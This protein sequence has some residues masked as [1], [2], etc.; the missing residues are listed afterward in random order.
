VTPDLPRLVQLG[1]LI[2]ICYAD[3][4][5]SAPGRFNFPGLGYDR[6][7]ILYADDVD[8]TKPYG[9]LLRD[10]TTGETVVPLRGTEG[11]WEWAEDGQAV[12]VDCPFFPPGCHIE[13]GFAR[14][15]ATLRDGNNVPLKQRAAALR[16][17]LTV[18]GHSLGAA[19]A[20]LAAA[21]CQADNLVTFASPRV[22]DDHFV[23]QAS[24]VIGHVTRIVNVR[25]L[26]P[27]VPF[28]LILAP[29]KFDHLGAAD[30][31]DSAGQAGDHPTCWH[32]LETYLHLLDPSIPV[33]PGCAVA[34][35]T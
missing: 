13:Q 15:Y 6:A 12:L 32:A 5:L 26:V 25:D 19:L 1:K 34:S 27:R 14:I 21:D 22:G 3:D 24:D 16:R 11:F 8:G 20:T 10:Q 2:R 7:A 28:S 30:C 35:P 9:F 23:S 4:F 33:A 17:P 18:T 31:L 29:F